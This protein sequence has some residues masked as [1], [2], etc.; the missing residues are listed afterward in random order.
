MYS[1]FYSSFGFF[2]K[3]KISKNADVNGKKLTQKQKGMLHHKITIASHQHQ[4]THLCFVGNIF[5]WLTIATAATPFFHSTNSPLSRITTTT[6]S[7]KM[8]TEQVKK[9]QRWFPLESNPELIN[10]YIQKL[11][12]D[13]S[14]YAFTDVFSTEDWALEMIPQPVAAVLLLYPL[15]ET[16]T[17]HDDGQENVVTDVM[18]DKVWFTKQRI[19]NACGTI[20]LLHALLNAPEPLRIFEADS[21]L[22]KFSEDCPIPLDPVAKAERLE[23]DSK[24][25]KLHDDAT[26][27]AANSTNR[28]DI[29]DKVETHFIALVCVDDKLYELDGRKDGPVLH[30]PT[31]QATLLQDSCQVI[32]QFMAR[33]PTEGRFAITTLAPKM[34]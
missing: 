17:K 11:G 2:A 33:D 23:E 15:T 18:Q 10:G 13:T 9:R 20:G 3:T 14:L 28:G 7:S 31:T 21:W 24:I 32:K 27:S 1:H 6:T 25:A 8:A 29:N 16:I 5:L 26:S 4:Q 19:G 30:G 12:F 34:Q 22:S